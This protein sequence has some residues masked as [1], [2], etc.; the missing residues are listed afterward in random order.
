[1]DFNFGNAKGGDGADNVRSPFSIFCGRGE[2]DA[3]GNV[4]SLFDGGG[5]ESGESRYSGEFNFNF[6]AAD[7]EK[8]SPN[9]VFNMF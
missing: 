2:S 1:M 3:G 6:G 5:D 4:F 9:G 7:T 8:S